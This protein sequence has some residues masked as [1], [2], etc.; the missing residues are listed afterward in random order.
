MLYKHLKT[1][2]NLSNFESYF[3]LSFLPTYSF[4]IGT[5]AFSGIWSFPSFS[6][7]AINIFQTIPWM[8]HFHCNSKLKFELIVVIK[9]QSECTAQWISNLSYKLQSVSFI[10]PSPHPGAMQPPDSIS[11]VPTS[12]HEHKT[13][14]W[15]SL[16]NPHF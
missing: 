13:K 15:W 6:Y 1:F 16:S 9:I 11:C 4:F 14:P 5:W 7:F 2:W 10:P 3:W 12:G 8:C